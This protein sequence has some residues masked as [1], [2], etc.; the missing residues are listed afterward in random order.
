MADEVYFLPI[1]VEYVTK[2]IEKERPDGILL[3]FGGQTA[4]NCGIH[5]KN[6]EILEKFNVQVLGTPI[7][8]IE[9]TEDRPAFADRLSILNEKVAPSRSATTVSDALQAADDICYPVLLRSA[10]ALGGAVS[11][12]AK[13]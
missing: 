4:L 3:Q 13:F 11:G 1:T 6:Q 12:F 10:F 5:L 9:L 2:V 8:I 7:E